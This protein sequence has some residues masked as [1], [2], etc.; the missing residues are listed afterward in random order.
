MQ[1]AVIAEVPSQLSDLDSGSIRLVSVSRHSLSIPLYSN[2]PLI[3]HRCPAAIRHG[4]L[5]W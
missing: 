2:G 5:K 3:G 4:L 1:G